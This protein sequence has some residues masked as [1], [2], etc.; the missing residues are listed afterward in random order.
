MN[1][2]RHIPALQF[3]DFPKGPQPGCGMELAEYARVGPA[4]LA[5]P[6]RITL[7]NDGFEATRSL[8]RDNLESIRDWLNDALSERAA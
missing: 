8:T 2:M 3:S 1:V 4:E 5:F 7:W 6:Y